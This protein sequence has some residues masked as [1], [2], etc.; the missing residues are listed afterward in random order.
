MKLYFIGGPVDGLVKVLSW[1]INQPV[2][3]KIK[4][5]N[6]I[7]NVL[8]KNKFKFFRGRGNEILLIKKFYKE[9]RYVKSNKD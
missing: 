9:K 6:P 4:S 2:F 3:I 1:Y 8:F 7:K 5:N